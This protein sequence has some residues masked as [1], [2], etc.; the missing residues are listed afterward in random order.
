VLRWFYP[1]S[2]LRLL[3]I[4]RELYQ[5]RRARS[6]SGLACIGL[7]LIAANVLAAY[8]LPQRFDLTAER[9][10]TLSPDT[11]RILAHIDEPVTLRF[12]YS[13]PLGESVPGYGIYERRV[14][15][16]LDQYVAAAHGKLR[17][18]ALD[19]QPFSASEERAVAFGLQGA[20]LNEQGEQGY[21]GLA[22][23]NS[24]DDREVIALFDPARERLLEYDLTRL[25]HR[26]AF[27]Q[28]P[29][30]DLAALR[31]RRSSARPFELVELVQR[32]ADALYAAE[33][34]VLE[35]QLEAAQAKLHDLTA[36]EA[37]GAPPAPDQARAIVQLRA[38]LGATRRRL[39]AVQA[40]LH[41]NIGRLKAILEFTDIA[42][43]PILVAVAALKLAVS[44]RRRRRP[45]VL[46]DAPLAG[47]SSA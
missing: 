2:L 4:L 31:S 45:S 11:T 46:R 10:Y 9:L 26:L 19:P 42:L 1:I 34:R 20:P 23:T 15:A 6:L 28:L 44:R 25:V 14:R 29:L 7:L 18:E 40:A 5:S 24:T 16:L 38:E 13:P 27:P 12:Y 43:V 39:R 8:Y 3:R 17:L 35:Q 32:Q 30:D 47:R 33:Q 36:G 37:G 22:G 41:E 21:F